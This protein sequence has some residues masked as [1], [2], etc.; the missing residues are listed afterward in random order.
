MRLLTIG[1]DLG[2]VSVGAEAALKQITG[3][4]V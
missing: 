3:D 1:G 2:F 4:G